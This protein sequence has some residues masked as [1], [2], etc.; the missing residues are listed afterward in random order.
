MEAAERLARLEAQAEQNADRIKE[1]FSRLD[2]PPWEGS[3]R[4]RLHTIMAANAADRLAVAAL[5]SA[6]EYAAEAQ[7]DRIRAEKARWSTGWRVFGALV[8]LVT[9][10]T[11]YVLYALAR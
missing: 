2:G 5:V 11:P 3:M 7:A 8:A 1:L 9:V 6:Q 10:A 4:E